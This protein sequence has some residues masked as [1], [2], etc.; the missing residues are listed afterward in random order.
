MISKEWFKK[1]IELNNRKDVKYSHEFLW[2]GYSDSW[3]DVFESDCYAEMREGKL[4]IFSSDG[5][6]T[7]FVTDK[8]QTETD[9]IAFYKL[10]T[11]KDLIVE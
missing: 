6:D 7:S 5:G 9:L 11:G 10:V 8:I 2:F 3:R 4:M 1:V